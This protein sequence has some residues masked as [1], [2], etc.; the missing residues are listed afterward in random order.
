MWK[1]THVLGALGFGLG[2]GIW[3][4]HSGSGE[5]AAEAAR[6]AVETGATPAAKGAAR[7]ARKA[8]TD[9]APFTGSAAE[10]VAKFKSLNDYGEASRYLY[11]ALHDLEPA[12]MAT[13]AAELQA[14][15]NQRGWVHEIATTLVNVWAEQDPAAALAWAQ[16]WPGIQQKMLVAMVLGIVAK[17]NPDE[18]IQQ[19]EQLPNGSQRQQALAAI[20]DKIAQTDP[21][22]ALTML[23]KQPS[24]SGSQSGLYSV[25]RTWAKNDP[26]AALAALAQ[27]PAS[28]RENLRS[29]I[30]SQLASEDPAAAQAVI[31][32]ITDP[33]E[34]AQARSNL[35]TNLAYND[36]E[37]A[38]A[39]FLK[40][41]LEERNKLNDSS[42]FTYLARS[43][44]QKAITLLDSLT[45][46]ARARAMGSI[47]SGWAQ[48]DLDG[49]LQWAQKISS[50]TERSAAL[51]NLSS[52]ILSQDMSKILSV[53]Q[54]ITSRSERINFLSNVC[55]GNDGRSAAD[56]KAMFSKL[57]SEDVSKLIRN[58]SVVQQMAKSDPLMA[59]EMVTN[60]ATNESTS[61][62]RYIAG[63]Y[64]KQ[65]LEA[66]YAWA[67][68]LPAD[69]AP[70]A[71]QA[72]LEA[73]AKTDLPGALQ[74][75]TTLTDTDVRK[76]TLSDIMSH[77]AST[78]VEGLERAYPNLPEEQRS[79]A[80]DRLISNK[81][82]KDPAAAAGMLLS[83]SQS[84]DPKERAF[85]SDRY[86]NLASRWVNENPQAAAQWAQQLPAGDPQ[87]AFVR[88]L[89]SN[90]S[91][92]DPM[93]ASIWIKGLPAGQGKDKAVSALISNIRSSDPASAVVWAGQIQNESSRTSAYQESLRALL[94]KDPTA[95]QS[96]VQAAP[97]SQAQKDRLLKPN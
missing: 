47:V 49:A 43:D 82:S 41:S 61:H 69:A 57:P 63:A 59:A 60:Y 55:T 23:L 20:A 32:Q 33:D 4:G 45:G 25:F 31:S 75:A 83:L 30:L 70:S 90:W 62:W 80:L 50:E 22:R 42:L 10:L 84:N 29:N 37:A 92:E 87:D 5:T 54:L 68:S 1:L 96:A 91:Q 17:T 19:A 52:T 35:V 3:I 76:R 13:F 71:L 34:R 6:P 88:T 44:P 72:V 16:N 21:Q 97:L 58:S 9:A 39:A 85:A 24:T 8:R 66:A 2:V 15:P 94:K 40:L 46:D 7:A 89:A 11:D 73:Q 78:D 14:L 53:A 93:N 38:T 48:N 12:R 56:L 86:S 74:R 18:A 65:N 79:A 51:S 95:G 26:Q 81:T 28:K 27:V 64:A 67:G 36:P 77:W